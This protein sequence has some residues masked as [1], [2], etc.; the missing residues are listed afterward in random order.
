MTSVQLRSLLDSLGLTQRDTA[1]RLGITARHMNRYVQGELK[2]PTVV[3]LAVRHMAAQCCPC[4]AK[5]RLVE[6]LGMVVGDLE[7]MIAG[8]DRGEVWVV[9]KGTRL[10]LEMA[11][12]A[13]ALAKDGAP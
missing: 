3:E 2:I 11:L 4:D 5:E 10:R 12:A 7:A 6:A 1:K 9:K 13:L 8:A